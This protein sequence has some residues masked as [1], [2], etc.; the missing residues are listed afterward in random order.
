MVE[1]VLA[2]KID[3]II[4]KSVSRFARN[5]ADSLVPKYGIP[6]TST[7]AGFSSAIINTSMIRFARHRT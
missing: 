4:T 5:T 2:G 6:T 3:L 1:D 7:K